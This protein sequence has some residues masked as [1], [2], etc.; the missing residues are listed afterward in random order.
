MYKYSPKG[1]FYFSFLYTNYLYLNVQKYFHLDSKMSIPPVFFSIQRNFQSLNFFKRK[2]VITN[3]NVMALNVARQKGKQNKKKREKK[4]TLLVDVNFC[5]NFPKKKTTFTFT[6][7]QNVNLR[8][9]N[10]V[11]FRFSKREERKIQINK[12]FMAVVLFFF[13]FRKTDS[14]K[15]QRFYLLIY[16]ILPKNTICN[17][18]RRVF[19]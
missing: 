13:I 3:L 11:I 2:L 4:I 15:N 1:K 8:D 19:Y 14:I 9:V 10:Y 12:I 16:E 17:C 5:R 18:I 6:L 7:L